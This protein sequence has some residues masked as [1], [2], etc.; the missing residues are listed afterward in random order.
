[1]P[2]LKSFTSAFCFCLL[3]TFCAVSAKVDTTYTYTG[4][5]Y[6]EGAIACP[7]ECNFTGSFTLQRPFLRMRM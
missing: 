4:A 7:P 6:A 1:M 2:S 5:Q 3:M